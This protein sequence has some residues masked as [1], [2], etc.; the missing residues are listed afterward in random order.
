[1]PQLH[2]KLTVVS[3]CN[4]IG[5]PLIALYH[6]LE[7][8]KAQGHEFTI[9]NTVVIE[10]N[11]DAAKLNESTLQRHGYPG[12]IFAI[13]KMEDLSRWILEHLC[14]DSKIPWKDTMLLVMT[15][16]P[17]KSISYG[18]K[19]NKNRT[20]FGL[21][22]SPSNVWFQAHSAIFQLCQI[23]S[24]ADRIIMVEN[25][26]P[27]N[28]EDLRTLDEM[29]GFRQDMSSPANH[30]GTRNRYAWTSIPIDKEC[31][32]FHNFNFL[33]NIEMPGTHA[34]QTNRHFPVL[35][36]IF[37]K[38]IGDLTQE[39]ITLSQQDVQ[40]VSDCYVLHQESN[41][42]ILPPVALWAAQMGM[43]NKML[44]ALQSI[45]PCIQDIQ[46]Y[47]PSSG[48]RR[49]KCGFNTYC[50]SCS[51]VISHVGEAWNLKTTTTTLFQLLFTFCKYR[52]GPTDYE[53]TRQFDTMSFQ[54]NYVPHTCSPSCDKVRRTLI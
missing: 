9:I 40:T 50:Q 32:P 36:A 1:M 51:T 16:T 41:E 47:S 18:C 38:L 25:V 37:P 49:E 2:I 19:A 11:E 24:P 44:Q 34:F 30:G 26:V 3:M 43:D 6:S 52:Q 46:V 35:R 7:L 31:P 27:P 15:G 20:Q 39:S 8:I 21:H 14:E 12:N 17:C 45:F 48:T 28:L 54:Y 29:A 33:D 22:A 10:H 42:P 5:V 53:V 13:K 4:G 23:F